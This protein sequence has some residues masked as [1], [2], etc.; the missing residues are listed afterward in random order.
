MNKKLL[1]L[2]VAVISMTAINTSWAEEP[3]QPVL[4]EMRVVLTVNR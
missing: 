3:P 2:I 4:P 1:A